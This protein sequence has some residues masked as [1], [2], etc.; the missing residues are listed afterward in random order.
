MD[1]SIKNIMIISLKKCSKLGGTTNIRI[2]TNLRNKWN[3]IKRVF[4]DEVIY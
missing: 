4:E 1:K 3:N 2:L